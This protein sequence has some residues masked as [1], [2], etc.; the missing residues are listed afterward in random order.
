[1]LATGHNGLLTLTF[2]RSSGFRNILPQSLYHLQAKIGQSHT[3]CTLSSLSYPHSWHSCRSVCPSLH[4]W[5]LRLVW[6]VNSP[7][8]AL[9]L[10]LL[11]ARSCNR[12]R[13][14]Y[15]HFGLSATS[16]GSSPGLIPHFQ[17]LFD[18][19]LPTL[20]GIA[21]NWLG[22]TSAAR[23]LASVSAS[24]FPNIS[25]CPGI[26]TKVTLLNSLSFPST[27]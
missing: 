27:C 18:E 16:T 14:S 23:C 24:S 11:I 3:M 20:K 26:H 17:L 5:A 22:G 10:N 21:V 9:S 1:V 2:S 12:Q 25:W 13:V 4:K 6:P 7:T 15:Q 8:A 19:F